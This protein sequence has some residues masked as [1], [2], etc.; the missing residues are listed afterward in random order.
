LHP[1]SLEDWG[2]N[3]ADRLG[4]RADE[5]VRAVVQR[6]ATLFGVEDNFDIYLARA[7]VSLVEVEA[8]LPASL[9]VPALLLSSV[10]RREAVLQIARALARLRAGSYLATRLSA[11]ELG[12]VLAG[13]L[14]S[15]YPDYGRG[16]G[17]E[18]SLVEMERQ[19][20]RLL[21][22]RHRRAFDK[23]VIGVAEAGPLDVSRWRQAMTH[24]AHRA[25]LVATGDVLGCLEHIIRSDRRLAAAATTP[26]GDMLE[27]ARSTPEVIEAVTFV[28]SDE[29]V[30]LRNQVA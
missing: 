26:P 25:S 2:L 21:P 1:L 18:D 5:P 3:R 19:V 8:T 7:G 16:L 14:R 9:L 6:L 27:L 28:L 23:A 4:P 13:S 17:S 15:R 30:M 29:Y 10:P 20:S 22:R 12:V 24:T 11:R